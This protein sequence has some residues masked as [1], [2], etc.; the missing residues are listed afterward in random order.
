MA[1]DKDGRPEWFPVL[2]SGGF[3]ISLLVAIGVA[4]YSVI[5]HTDVYP[6]V[7]S[8]SPD[9]VMEIMNG[10]LAGCVTMMCLMLCGFLFC[11]ICTLARAVRR[12]IAK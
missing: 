9:I 10:V 3:I 6:C 4:T 8:C 11:A 1:A 5:F 2:L 7:Y 12:G